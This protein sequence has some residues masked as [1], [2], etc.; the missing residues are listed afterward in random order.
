MA[1]SNTDWATWQ[2]QVIKEEYCE[3]GAADDTT[4]CISSGQ[5]TGE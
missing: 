2:K 4:S 1:N 5:V 3:E